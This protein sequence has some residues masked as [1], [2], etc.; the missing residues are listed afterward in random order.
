MTPFTA[1]ALVLALGPYD[2]PLLPGSVPDA[3]RFAVSIV[4]RSH[5]TVS[6]RVDPI[7]RGYI[8]SFCTPSVCSVSRVSVRL[9]ANGRESIELQLVR[10]ANDAT[11]PARVT[12]RAL[13]AVPASLAFERGLPR[14]LP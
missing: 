6:V 3:A 13:G 8:A 5:Q 11:R 2:G 14:R 1:L 7:P 4:G 9:P 12:V 10:N